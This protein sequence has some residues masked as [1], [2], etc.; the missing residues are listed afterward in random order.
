MSLQLSEMKCKLFGFVRNSFGEEAVQ[1]HAIYKTVKD[2]LKL[3]WKILICLLRIEFVLWGK[4]F[5]GMFTAHRSDHKKLRPYWRELPTPA[6][7]N[8]LTGLFQ[9]LFQ[10]FL[11]RLF[12]HKVH[13]AVT[14]TF[15]KLVK[16]STKTKNVYICYRQYTLKQLLEACCFISSAQFKFFKSMCCTYNSCFPFFFL[17]TA[18]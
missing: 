6:G 8:E 11:L 7:Q 2:R 9:L 14:D 12:L 3:G 5:L 4:F 10:C 18:C 17:G 13:M 15:C 16:A 1:S